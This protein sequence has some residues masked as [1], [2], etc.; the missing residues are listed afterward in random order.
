WSI[1]ETKIYFRDFKSLLPGIVKSWQNLRA[2][3]STSDVLVFGHLLTNKPLSSQ[4]IILEGSD[5]GSFDDFYKNCWIKLQNG[6]ATDIK[7]EPI[8]DELRS[9]C[10]LNKDQ[11][12]IFAS[13]FILHTNYEGYHP[14]I[15]NGKTQKDSDLLDLRNLLL[16]EV[17]SPD[18]RIQLDAETIVNKLGWGF[19][20]QTTFN[21][22]LIVDP[23]KYQPI[24]GTISALNKTIDSHEGG[25]IFLEGSP[26][27]G[28]STLLSQWAKDRPDRVIK[29]F[30]FDFTDPTIRANASTRGDGI[31]L[32]YDLVLQ[33]KLS[34]GKF[35]KEETIPY[36]DHNFLHKIFYSQ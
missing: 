21:H 24:K 32:L 5:L 20:F 35:Y 7:W 27:S 31:S 30:A 25:Y 12:R 2:L 16:K 10:S 28:K 1:N 33:I 23:K 36:Y 8:L 26:G 19:K 6:Q 9:D 22:E 3:H 18:R 29:Y 14:D 4:D 13:Q 11:F 17:S 34:D 15:S